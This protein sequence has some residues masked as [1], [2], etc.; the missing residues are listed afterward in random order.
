MLNFNEELEY[1]PR[2]WGEV[3]SLHLV[4][5]DS[6]VTRICFFYGIINDLDNKTHE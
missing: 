3:I 4:S 6:S 5:H 1:L 2:F